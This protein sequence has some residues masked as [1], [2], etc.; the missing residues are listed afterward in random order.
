MGNVKYALTPSEY[1]K[2]FAKDFVEGNHTYGDLNLP[3]TLCKPS[4]KYE[5]PEQEDGNGALLGAVIGAGI[6]GIEGGIVGYILG[7][8][9]DD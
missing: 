7:S 6:N 1:H 4:K 8:I 5:T 2:E 3:K 9:L